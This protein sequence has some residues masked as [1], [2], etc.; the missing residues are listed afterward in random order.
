M[1]AALGSPHEVSGAAYLPAGTVLPTGPPLRSAAVAL[2]VEGPA[3]SVAFRRDSLIRE[4]GAAGTADALADAEFD[5]VVAD[6]RRS[7]AAFRSAGP[8]GV[9][10]L[11]SPR[12]AVPNWARRSRALLM[13]CGFS[14][15]AAASSGRR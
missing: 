7:R 9:A 4:H 10:H 3:S 6:H 15:G 14:I 2:R 12:R 5:R 11:G 8:R 1:A 13:R